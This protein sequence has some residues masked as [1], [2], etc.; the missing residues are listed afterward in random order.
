[1]LHKQFHERDVDLLDQTGGCLAVELQQPRDV[2]VE[3]TFDVVK[4]W[5]EVLILQG[6]SSANLR[7]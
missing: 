6:H 1:M 4:E 7:K 5:C 3:L 2:A